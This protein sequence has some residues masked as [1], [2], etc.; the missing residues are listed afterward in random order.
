MS[1][2]TLKLTKAESS[3]LYETFREYA[4]DAPAYADWQIRPEGCVITCYTSGKVVFQ[5]KDAEVYAFPFQAAEDVILPQGGSDEVGTG[6]YFGPVCVTA[7]I[8]T[9]ETLGRIQRLGVKDSKAVTDA[10]IRKI[11]PEL[12]TMLPHSTLIV[13]P[14]KYNAVHTAN[15]M[16]AIKAKLHNQAYVNLSRKTELPSFCV[17]DQFAEKPIYYHYL[18]Q[19]AKVIRTLHF[20]TK[21]ENKY[22]AVGAASILARYAFLQFMDEMNRTYDMQFAKGSGAP[23]DACARAFVAKYGKEKLG[24]V[25][26]LHF[27][28]TEKL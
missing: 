1:T 13:S 8:V 28:N 12:N 27:R 19:E 26:K 17:V 25:A 16:N 15:N 2:I 20:E 23:A 7:A 18:K 14:A 9:A 10:L 4:S 6:D 24:E 3:R 21:A 22:P 5:G 11:A